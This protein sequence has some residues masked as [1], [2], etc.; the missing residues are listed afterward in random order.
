MNLKLQGQWHAACTAGAAIYFR[1]LME[2]E[3]QMGEYS[4]PPS[5]DVSDNRQVDHRLH[6]TGPV[7]V[8]RPYAVPLEPP[9]HLGGGGDTRVWLTVWHQEL[10]ATASLILPP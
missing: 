8:P 10:K 3:V 1:I 5:V 7:A 6:R 4:R 2:P 9:A